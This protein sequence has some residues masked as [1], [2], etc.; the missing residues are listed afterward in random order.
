M[1]RKNRR[2][3]P[4]VVTGFVVVMGATSK[5]KNSHQRKVKKFNLS[6]ELFTRT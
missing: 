3:T 2:F 4:V 1:C 6:S 5:T